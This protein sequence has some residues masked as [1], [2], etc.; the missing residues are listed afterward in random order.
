MIKVTWL[1]L[2]LV[3]LSQLILLVRLTSLVRA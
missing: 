2:R 3:I 1:S